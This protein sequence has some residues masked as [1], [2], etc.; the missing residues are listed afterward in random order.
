[1]ILKFITNNVE[2]AK[3]AEECGVDRIFLD[4]EFIGKNLRQG[5]LD[6]LISNHTV[7]DVSNLKK[8][9]SNSELLVRV[10]PI[11]VN[12]KM[13]IDQV[14]DSGADI[15][16]LPMFKYKQEV[17]QFIQIVN[18]R[19]KVSLLLETPNSLLNIDEILKCS[20]NI[21]EIHIGLNDLHIAMGLKFM[22]EIIAGDLIDT[23]AKKITD[24]KIKLGIGGI[25]CIGQ[26]K[27]KAENI[28]TEYIRL[29]S[30]MVILS[31]TFHRNATTVD[32]LKNMIDLKTEIELLRNEIYKVKSFG[33]IDFK[34]NLLELKKDVWNFVYSL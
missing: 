25:A 10:N 16:M 12:S 28:L 21:D 3:Y 6:T 33:E 22:F 9:L 8:A 18:G 5:H 20:G 2:L 1:M 15:I 14:I 4:L 7:K 24:K 13:E 17:D 31:R 19:S 32:E 34:A 11:N 23:I 30:E 29:G 26:G 27:I